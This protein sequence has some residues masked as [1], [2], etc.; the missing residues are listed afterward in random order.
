MASQLLHSAVD[1]E[2]KHLQSRSMLSTDRD[3][4][5]SSWALSRTAFIQAVGCPEQCCVKANAVRDSGQLLGQR[6][7]SNSFIW[8]GSA[9]KS[10]ITFAIS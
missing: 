5:D 1:P 8:Q 6:W 3:S 10:L 9:S 4:T 2:S 7:R